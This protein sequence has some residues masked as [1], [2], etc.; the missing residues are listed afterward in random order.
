MALNN[1]SIGVAFLWVVGIP[2]DDVTQ[3][4]D[5]TLYCRSSASCQMVWNSA[6]PGVLDQYGN[7]WVL[8]ITHFQPAVKD[9]KG[10]ISENRA[11]Q[12]SYPEQMLL[13]QD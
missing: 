10:C 3:Y 2:R 6:F 12:G 9:L 4:G 8:A 13:N 1:S 5:Q 7:L 11:C